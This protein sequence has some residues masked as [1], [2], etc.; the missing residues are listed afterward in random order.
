MKLNSFDKDID[1]KIEFIKDFDKMI[2]VFNTL[3]LRKTDQK[4]NLSYY[5]KFSLISKK[6]KK[7]DKLVIVKKKI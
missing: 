6:N 3:I 1:E 2:Y 5:Y 4:P 7:K